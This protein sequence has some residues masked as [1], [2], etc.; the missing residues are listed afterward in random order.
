VLKIV[1]LFLTA[2]AA[3]QLIKPLGWPGLRSRRDAWKLPVVGMVIM[4]F[5]IAWTATF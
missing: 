4:L 5:W 2:L 3:I 1:M